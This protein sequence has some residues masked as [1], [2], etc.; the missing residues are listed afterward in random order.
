MRTEQ[1]VQFRQKAA[2]KSLDIVP[3]YKYNKRGMVC[4]LR[5]SQFRSGVFHL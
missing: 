2:K 1:S 4:A 5:D 3:E